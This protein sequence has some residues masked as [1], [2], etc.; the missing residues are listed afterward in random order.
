MLIEWAQSMEYMSIHITPNHPLFKVVVD[1]AFTAAEKL[2]L[3]IE[4]GIKKVWAVRPPRGMVNEYYAAA[5][6]LINSG[7]QFKTPEQSRGAYQDA[8]NTL[9]DASSVHRP[10]DFSFY[11]NALTAAVRNGWEDAARAVLQVPYKN[12]SSIEGTL[13][14]LTKEGN[15][16]AVNLAI[17][18]ILEMK[19]L[20]PRT[21]VSLGTL[22]EL[23]SRAAEHGHVHIMQEYIPNTS[24]ID[25]DGAFSLACANG[26]VEVVKFLHQK[27]PRESYYTGRAFR[28]ALAGKHEEI[29][30]WLMEK[31][32]N[33]ADW[34]LITAAGYGCIKTM[35]AA[36]DNGAKQ[37]DAAAKNAVL[38]IQSEA[39]SVLIRDFGANSDEVLLTAVS[40]C[41]QKMVGIAIEEGARNLQEAFEVAVGNKDIEMLE[42]FAEK[43][44][45]IY[46]TVTLEKSLGLKTV[47]TDDVEIARWIVNR[48]DIPG[49]ESELL[50]NFVDWLLGD[51]EAD[52]EGNTEE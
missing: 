17:D 8:L 44:Q 43:A 32:A 9:S 41:I 23:F 4:A 33:S 29:S 31:K 26:H 42:L 15:L 39:L 47:G 1:Y 13:R 27:A 12:C 51:D 7:R 2:A 46:P 34:V 38:N 48:W 40:A 5:L 22:G 3:V 28:K 21:K 45:K 14:Q 35:R 19:K 20:R 6:D 24:R 30:I 18:I 52:A 25:F 49:D 36:I 50:D 10:L 16:S 37:V 11:D